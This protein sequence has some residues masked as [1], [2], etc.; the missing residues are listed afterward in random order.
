MCWPSL[1]L[2]TTYIVNLLFHLTLEDWIE[3]PK[4]NTSLFVVDKV[5]EN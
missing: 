4:H 2:Y 5:L 1:K 3:A